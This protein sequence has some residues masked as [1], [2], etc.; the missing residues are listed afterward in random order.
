M[1]RKI[2]SGMPR[3]RSRLPPP[4]RSN[5]GIE[6]AYRKRLLRLIDD[7]HRSLTY[8][9][10]AAYRKREPHSATLMAADASPAVTLRDAMRR[11]TRYWMRKFDD[12]ASGL[13]GYFATTAFRRS[14][15][16][17]SAILNRGGF[18]VKFRM[19]RAAND[20]LQAAVAEN[21]GLIKSIAQQH[22]SRVEGDVMRSVQTGRD[23]EQLVGDLERNYGVTRRRAELIARDQNNKATATIIRVRQAELGIT[24]A[25][26][27]HSGGGKEPRPSHL[28]AGRDRVRYDVKKGWYDPDEDRYVFP[29]ELINC[30]CVSRPVI[31][32]FE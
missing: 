6:A 29:G 14:D 3:S 17:L 1:R 13:A 21:V 5:A 23:L 27:V 12:A 24:E 26:W 2:R 11:L 19:G 16:T 32:G 15:A 30:R 28:K 7:M 4:V 8:W 20:V 18:S 10:R 9:L 25:V 22:L 31:P